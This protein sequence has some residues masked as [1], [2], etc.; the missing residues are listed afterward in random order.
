VTRTLW[1]HE[2]VLSSAIVK[3]GAQSPRG[4]DPD[5]SE[6]AVIAAEKGWLQQP[7]DLSER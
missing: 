5:R 2:R 6:A 1:L 3:A 4:G 7:A